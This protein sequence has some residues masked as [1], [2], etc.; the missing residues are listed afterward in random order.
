MGFLEQDDSRNQRA[1]FS[2]GNTQS[3][4]KLTGDVFYEWQKTD[5]DNALPYE[6]EQV[7]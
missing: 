3:G 1:F 4:R 5:Y 7:G 6:Y 2:Y